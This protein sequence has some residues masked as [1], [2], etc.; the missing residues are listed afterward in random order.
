MFDLVPFRRKNEDVVG[1]MLKSFH[2]LF[3]QNFLAP[4]NSN[5]HHFCT[6]IRETKQA[7]LIEAE[8]PGFSKD[9]IEVNYSNGYLTIKATR[10]RQEEEKDKHD[11]V[12]RKERYHGEFVRRFYVEHIDEDHIKAKLQD[13]VL[14]LEIPKKVTSVPADKRVTI[15]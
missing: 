2:D 9:D 1:S 11:K 15:E 10:N 12:I 3:E 7:Y 14:K 6:D 4:L 13:G 8:L 5:T